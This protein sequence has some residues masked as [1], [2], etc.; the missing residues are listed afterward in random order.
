[1]GRS[2]RDDEALAAT[3]ES[4]LTQTV[5][6]LAGSTADLPFGFCARTDELPLVWTLNQLCVLEPVD[7][8]A[9]LEAAERCQGHLAYRHVVVREAAAG[10]QVAP[11][12]AEAQWRVEREVVMALDV[13]AAQHLPATD[14]GELSED[15][16]L[17]LMAAWLQEERPV[18]AD[19]VAQVLEYNRREGR[20]FD[21]RRFGVLDEVDSPVALTKLRVDGDFAWVEDVYARPTARGRGFGRSL[22]T[23]AVRGALD[24]GCSVVAI[25]A[26]ANDWPQ[27]LYAKLGFRPVSYRWIFHLEAEAPTN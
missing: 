6:W 23:R 15:Q 27:H 10:A 9:L 1:V 22:V 2:G 18:S 8:A 24:E 7:A 14:V 12:L 11:S 26:D 25:V 4:H 20:L 19:G 3:I 5:R 16:G 21:E 17:E 13:A